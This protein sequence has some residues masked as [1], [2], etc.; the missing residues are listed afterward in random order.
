[1][2][3]IKSN[4]FRSIK[5]NTFIVLLLIGIIYSCVPYRKT[6][7]LREKNS[8]YKDTIPTSLS[9]YKLHKN[10]ILS[11]NISS[12]N[13]NVSDFYNL[14]KDGGIGGF[15]INDNGYV[16]IPQLD[17]MYV[18]G[19]TVPEVESMISAKLKEQ[20]N[21]PYVVVRMVNFKIIFL[22]EIG[23][24]GV[25]QVKENSINILEAL[26]MAGNISEYGNNTEVKLVRQN[27]N[28]ST[29]I[30]MLDLTAKDIIASP[31]FYLQPNDVIYIQP[32][33]VKNFRTN[34]QL[35]ATILS[36]TTFVVVI[37]NFITNARR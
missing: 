20:I 33:R 36:L 25:I 3:N 4:Y 30:T 7:L 32:L 21:E 5:I 2:N 28:G 37:S 11:I 16:H 22:G 8:R 1:M 19:K 18:L 12:F 17:S 29:F 23:H 14:K 10:D 6:I 9:Y 31:Y 26:A 27:D 34:F 24:P 13:Q 35:V 15:L